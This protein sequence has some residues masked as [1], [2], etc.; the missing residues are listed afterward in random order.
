M[1][2][3]VPITSSSQTPLV[4]P[5]LA[6]S[7]SFSPRSVIVVDCGSGYSRAARYDLSSET[8]LIRSSKAGSSIGALHAV[9]GCPIRSAE[10][11]T[12]LVKL[13]EEV[14]PEACRVWIGATG[15]VRDLIASGDITAAEVGRFR[16]QLLTSDELPFEA[17]LIVLEGDDEA[18]YEFLSAEYCADKCGLSD[19]DG[20]AE[21]DRHLGLLSSGGMSSQIF[22]GG[23]SR[24]LQTEIKRGNRLGL[25]LG[26]EGGMSA[27]HWHATEAVE[28][29]LPE[30]FGGENVL[31]VAIEML[32]AVG[33]KAG[34]GGGV[35]VPV[36]DAIETLSD[37][38]KKKTEEDLMLGEEC[39]RTWKTYVHVMSGIVGKLILG[40]LHPG[41]KV[42]F[43][44]EF[45]LG[46]DNFLKPSWPLGHA[47]EKLMHE[48]GRCNE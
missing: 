25:E 22:V 48:A 46:E 26:M 5:S 32:A 34:M 42:L 36:S 33:E 24:C 3:S 1:T 29:K 6:K 18:R 9:L 14:D 20:G 16:E 38:I 21:A 41:S 27:F 23:I 4:A 28:Q 37:F 13:V 40:R 11:I 45:Q 44:R 2:V 12:R 47:I 17:T 39:E 8:D 43:L 35:I 7:S 10:W 30:N 19:R 31:Y 15:G